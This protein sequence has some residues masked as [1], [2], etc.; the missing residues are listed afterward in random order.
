MNWTSQNK[1]DIPVFVFDRKEYYQISYF[2]ENTELNN[3]CYSFFRFFRNQSIVS[4]NTD[5]VA[6]EF[7]QLHR[8]SNGDFTSK[9]TSPLVKRLRNA[10]SSNGNY[11]P[12]FAEHLEI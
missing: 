10:R 6:R 5:S 9:Q 7:T 11:F 8:K 3:Y 4:M 1:N 2:E 12:T